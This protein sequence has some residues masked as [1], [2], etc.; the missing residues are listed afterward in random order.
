MATTPNLTVEQLAQAFKELPVK[1]KIK[2]LNLLPEE[3]FESKTHKLTEKQ[4]EV[5]DVATQ[6]EVEGKSV[7]NSWT[8]VEH[9]V[10]TRNNA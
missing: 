10:R 2:L 5:L 7:F 3:W 6:K 8:D 9:Y 4:K 1:E